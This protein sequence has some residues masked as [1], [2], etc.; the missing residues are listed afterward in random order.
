MGSGWGGVGGGGVV[1]AYGQP[2]SVCFFDFL[3]EYLSIFDLPSSLS[4]ISMQT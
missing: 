2:R 3:F 1:N 4:Q